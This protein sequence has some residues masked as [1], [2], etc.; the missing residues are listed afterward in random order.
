VPVLDVHLI[1]LEAPGAILTSRLQ[2]LP[3]TLARVGRDTGFF[4]QSDPLE[5]G[6]TS[7]LAWAWTPNQTPRAGGFQQRQLNKYRGLAVHASG[8]VTAS[9]ALPTDSMGAL[10]NASELQTKTAML[11]VVAAGHLSTGQRIAVAASIS[12]ADRVWEGNPTEVGGRHQGRLRIQTDLALYTTP[13]LAV[14]STAVRAG[15]RSGDV[16]AELAARLIQAV[17]ESPN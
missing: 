4:A 2:A 14:L 15:G 11:L 1:P 5:A 3:N 6:N 7:T 10:I 17:R 12:P 9:E 13:D 8:Q 16:A